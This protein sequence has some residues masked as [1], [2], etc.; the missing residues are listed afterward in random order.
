MDCRVFALCC[1]TNPALRSCVKPRNSALLCE[2][3]EGKCGSVSPGMRKSRGYVVVVLWLVSL[4]MYESGCRPYRLRMASE[5]KFTPASLQLAATER[6]VAVLRLE[7][8]G[9]RRHLPM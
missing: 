7:T 6:L 4:E 2:E 5:L 1:L 3:R 8:C 9:A